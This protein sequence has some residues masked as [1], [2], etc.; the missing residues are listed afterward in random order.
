MC[1][2][3]EMKPR[4]NNCFRS[5]KTCPK[6]GLRQ[7][8]KKNRMPSCVF[9]HFVSSRVSPVGWPFHRPLSVGNKQAQCIAAVALGVDCNVHPQGLLTLG[10]LKI[11]ELGTHTLYSH[12]TS[13]VSW[14][15]SAWLW[16]FPHTP[17]TLGW[18]GL[19]SKKGRCL[20]FDSYADGYIRGQQQWW[21]PLGRSFLIPQQTTQGSTL[22][23][24]S[25]LLGI[26]AS[27]DDQWVRK[28]RRRRRIYWALCQPLDERA[29]GQEDH[30]RGDSALSSNSAS[31]VR[32][33]KWDAGMYWI[34]FSDL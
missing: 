12:P 15:A 2:Y 27:S 24:T 20:S 8:W 9:L 1:N 31:C 30:W 25:W 34:S 10:A 17:R 7:N 14:K 22:R 19:L 3:W 13:R 29:R 11:P 16:H 28:P 18:A 26:I 4:D 23:W 33:P 5:S 32:Q 21:E 6:P